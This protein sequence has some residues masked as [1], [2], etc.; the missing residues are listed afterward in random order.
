MRASLPECFPDPL[1]PSW[2]MTS[3]PI[4]CEARQIFAVTAI[5]CCV[6]GAHVLLLHE[7]GNTLSLR[8]FIS[9]EFKFFELAIDSDTTVEHI[10]KFLVSASEAS[11]AGRWGRSFTGSS[12]ARGG[13]P[14]VQSAAKNS[15]SSGVGLCGNGGLAVPISSGYSEGITPVTHSFTGGFKSSPSSFIQRTSN[16]ERSSSRLSNSVHS[17]LELEQQPN[18]T[19]ST[20]QGKGSCPVGACGVP[21]EN[22]S[23]I[24]GVLPQLSAR[25]SSRGNGR[26]F[27]L[28]DVP[29]ATKS[30][31]PSTGNNGPPPAASTSEVG[32]TTPQTVVAC[33]RG[34]HNASPAVLQAIMDA[35]SVGQVHYSGGDSHHSLGNA[36]PVVGKRD[37]STSGISVGGG[38]DHSFAGSSGA[39]DEL[40][41]RSCSASLAPPSSSGALDM[42]LGVESMMGTPILRDDRPV[43]PSLLSQSTSYTLSRSVHIVL[44]CSQKSYTEVLSESDRSAF[45]LSAFLS[46][47]NEN[48]PGMLY[49]LNLR[50]SNI[51]NKKRL[52]DLLNF[53]DA[54]DSVGVSAVVSGYLRHLL[55]VIR[56]SALPGNTVGGYAMRHPERY[57]RLLRAAAVLFDPG[58]ELLS[59]AGVYH[60]SVH[61]T[62]M[63]SSFT[64]GI[65]PYYDLPK[66]RSPLKM[67]DQEVAISARKSQIVT[68]NTSVRSIVEYSCDSTS[69]AHG[70]FPCFHPSTDYAS[71]GVSPFQ[72]LATH[73]PNFADVVVTATDVLCLL[74]PMIA[75]FFTIRVAQLGFLFHTSSNASLSSLHSSPLRVPRAGF[76]IPFSSSG[77]NSLSTLSSFH[78]SPSAIGAAPSDFSSR[79][80]NGLFSSH[81]GQSFSSATNA[82][83]GVSLSSTSSG[84]QRSSQELLYADNPDR[85]RNCGSGTARALRRGEERA[86]TAAPD[87]E[88]E[89]EGGMHSPGSESHFFDLR[90]ETLSFVPGPQRNFKDPFGTNA[91][92]SAIEQKSKKEGRNTNCAPQH[93]SLIP[94]GPDS[95]GPALLSYSE[96]R[97]FLR[98]VVIKY[99]HPAPG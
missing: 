57:L 11:L 72:G 61:S 7:Q 65:P 81:A 45:A 90:K 20:S 8:S 96:V 51:V 4:N 95:T 85:D 99:S 39:L 42:E 70:V 31:L 54:L 21:T 63:S 32:R 15:S 36:P 1:T 38:W 18:P 19:S 67:N 89:E 74:C 52:Q 83:V 59:S 41:S 16:A 9:K 82:P 78:H 49:T 68:S 12:A 76:S 60:H 24:I 44:F 92:G 55:L 58:L 25:K 94:I 93:H 2:P 43:S 50:H 40:H 56:G 79:N 35:V 28:T 66:S 27:S 88:E 53:P 26:L 97:E 10:S 84:I 47:L 62:S 98:Y 73:Q 22:S 69:D 77:G 91:D 80:K 13:L 30:K 6:P 14:A 87:G 34:V 75:H 86:R 29:T 48:Q 23:G 37:K 5:A 3:S 71:L 64:P 33:I 46:A 17:T